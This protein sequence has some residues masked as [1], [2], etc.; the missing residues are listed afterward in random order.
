MANI[1]VMLLIKE[2]PANM[3]RRV[4]TQEVVKILRNTRTVLLWDIK[5]KHLDDFVEKGECLDIVKGIDF[6]LLSLGSGVMRKCG[7]WKRGEADSS[8]GPCPGGKAKGKDEEVK[9]R[10]GGA[11]GRGGRRRAG[12][13]GLGFWRDKVTCILISIFVGFLFTYIETKGIYL[14]S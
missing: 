6:K 5:V 13:I 1:V 14:V 9:P 7:K 3:K 4:L 11:L 8:T 10:Q 12:G 2:I